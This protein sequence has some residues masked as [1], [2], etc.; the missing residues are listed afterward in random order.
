ML[1]I[2][3]AVVL[4]IATKEIYDELIEK[5]HI[6]RWKKERRDFEVFMDKL[7][8]EIADDED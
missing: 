6:W 4:A 2:Y 7:E 1:D 8:D 5:F 3:F